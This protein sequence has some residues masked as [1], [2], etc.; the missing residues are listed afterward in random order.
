MV[1][2][3]TLSALEPGRT[4][5]QGEVE[6]MGGTNVRR[7]YQCGKCSGGCPASFAM[8]AQPR[9][10]MRMVQLGDREGALATNTI[11]L[12]ASCLA[13]TTRCP[14]EVEIAGVMEALRIIS[15]RE[16]RVPSDRN[17][18]LFHDV[19]VD[20]IRRRGRLNEFELAMRYK[21]ASR[22]LFADIAQGISMM[23]RGKLAL[24]PHKYRGRAQVQAIFRRIKEAEVKRS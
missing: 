4:R 3:I 14:R 10:V 17:V 11:W 7:C 16:R 15:R 6:A 8:E 2:T 19:F 18:A 12:C 24:I 21:L 23:L 5:L 1:R 22:N 20:A 13:C 9:Q